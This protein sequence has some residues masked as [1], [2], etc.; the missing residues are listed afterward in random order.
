MHCSVENAAVLCENHCERVMQIWTSPSEEEEGEE[1]EEEE[2]RKKNIFS[3]WRLSGSVLLRCFLVPLGVLFSKT[4]NLLVII[5]TYSLS[6]SV[7][8]TNNFFWISI[9]YASAL[10]LH[11]ESTDY[12]LWV[13]LCV[14]SEKHCMQDL[15]ERL[16]KEYY[17]KKNWTVTQHS[18]KT[19]WGD[20]RRHPYTTDNFSLLRLQLLLT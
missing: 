15:P 5:T 4:A 18:I 10:S 11:R 14:T 1:E 8:M 17:A 12:D 9:Y 13:N 20:S 2:E 7:F 6:L 3:V 19:C 16:A